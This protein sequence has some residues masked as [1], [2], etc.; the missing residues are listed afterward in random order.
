MLEYLLRT[1][2]TFSPPPILS[3][4]P[5]LRIFKEPRP[6]KKFHTEEIIFNMINSVR[7]KSDIHSMSVCQWIAVYSYALYCTHYKPVQDSS[8][9][10][11][12]WDSHPLA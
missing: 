3:L 12:M 2:Q 5:Y 7:D 10:F 9:S 11:T 6:Q 8:L 4:Y 1:L